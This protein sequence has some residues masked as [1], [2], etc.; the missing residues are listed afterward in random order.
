MWYGCGRHSERREL[1]KILRLES[2]LPN[3]EAAFGEGRAI[4]GCAG[5]R[6]TTKMIHTP[7]ARL[8]TYNIQSANTI[9]LLKG[10]SRSRT[11]P[12]TPQQLPMVQTQLEP[13]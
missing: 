7:S 13:V 6:P 10:V 5:R 3:S 12:L 4:S 9:H 11:P 8:S 2:G 1:P